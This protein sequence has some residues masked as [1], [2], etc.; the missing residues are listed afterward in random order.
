MGQQGL[1]ISCQ[2]PVSI[3]SPV[4]IEPLTTTIGKTNRTLHAGRTTKN[5][6]SSLIRQQDVEINLLGKMTVFTKG[7]YFL[8]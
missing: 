7:M 2:V 1:R 3:Q 5:A 4:V 6:M 8:E